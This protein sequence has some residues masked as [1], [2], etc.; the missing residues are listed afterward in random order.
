VSVAEI[1]TFVIRRAFLLPLGLLLLLSVILLAVCIGQGEPT[2]RVLILGCVILPVAALFVES[3][4]RRAVVGDGELTVFKPMRRATL[5]F[6]DVSAVE[7]VAVRKRVFLTLCAGDDFL[8]LSNAYAD[9]PGL[10]RTLLARVPAE[11]VSPETAAMAEAPPVKQ[12]DIFA[13]WLA[14]GLMALILWAQL[15]K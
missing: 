13:C 9:F 1:R 14:V 8:I 5:K 4:W 11:A 12:G 10:V 2:A 7:T 6:A 15:G 3:A